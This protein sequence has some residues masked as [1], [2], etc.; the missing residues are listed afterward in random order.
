[1]RKGLT[2]FL[3]IILLSASPTALSQAFYDISPVKSLYSP[4]QGDGNLVFSLNPAVVSPTNNRVGGYSLNRQNGSVYTD[5]GEIE[6]KTTTKLKES[7][8]GG[9]ALFDLGAGAAVGISLER[10][11]TRATYE[12]TDTRQELEESMATQTIGGRMLIDVATG[13]RIGL[14]LRWMTERGDVLGSSGSNNMGDRVTYSGNLIGHGGGFSF[15]LNQWRIGAAYYPA[16]RG[17]S[18]IL[19]EQR[20]ITEPGVAIADGA[21]KVGKH[22]IG[23][24]LERSIHRRDERA[25]SVVSEDG[26]RDISLD[27]I[28][29]DK[30]ALPVSKMHLGFDASL[31]PNVMF[32]M[33]ITRHETEW[34]FD[35][36]KAPGDR[37]DAD[38]FNWNEYKVGGRLLAPYD[39]EAGI[40]SGTMSSHLTSKSGRGVEGDTYTGSTRSYYV[41][42]GLKF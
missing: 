16:V 39:I 32:K 30:S 27:G 21:L 24:G 17:K 31:L 4:N 6:E 5:V 37:D 41:T 35:G 15:A 22:M 40:Q 36:T 20:I 3:K 1:M 19:Y 18:E 11:H 10:S 13:L 14:A 12:I 29:P 26:D 33:G 9:M 8:Y 23:I 2:T 34:I 25:V 38:R 28:S 42:G 7:F